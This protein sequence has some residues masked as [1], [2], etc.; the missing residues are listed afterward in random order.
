MRTAT[1]SLA[2]S[3]AVPRRRKKTPALSQ[4]TRKPESTAKLAAQVADRIEAEIIRTGWTTGSN[5]GTEADLAAQYN[6]S[7]SIMREIT[8]QLERRGIATAKRGAGGGLVVSAPAPSAIVAVIGSYLE[9]TRV[10]LRDILEARAVLEVQAAGLAAQRIDEASVARLRDLAHMARVASGDFRDDYRNY[11]NVRHEVA[12]ASGNPLLPLLVQSLDFSMY[13]ITLLRSRPDDYLSLMEKSGEAKRRLVEAICD[14]DVLAAQELAQHDCDLQLRG[15]EEIAQQSSDI[16]FKR[17]QDGDSKV[18]ANFALRL[19]QDIRLEDLPPGRQ[20][21]FEPELMERYGVGR[22]AF[23][24]GVR[25]LEAHSIVTAK[26]GKGGGIYVAQPNPAHTIDVAARYISFMHFSPDEMIE[27][28]QPLE[29]H[30]AK[31]G[32]K[33]I[34][35]EQARLIQARLDDSAAASDPEQMLARTISTHEAICAAS[36]N[37][38]VTLLVQIVLHALS[39]QISPQL[40]HRKEVVEFSLESHRR[41]AEA[42]IRRDEGAAARAMLRHLEFLTAWYRDL[43]PSRRTQAF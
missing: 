28:R 40:P 43:F 25:V 18:G 14:C 42:V 12:R 23:R 41:I 1:V 37:E 34:T 8:G 13:D 26:R 4:D 3:I 6:V 36:Q 32:A 24:E 39:R 38:V 33:R 17:G 27:V 9:Y 16:S 2:L 15:Y 7:R 30:A 19:S 29:V 20:L 21:G 22:T 10:D 5:I 35:D 31:A 11:I